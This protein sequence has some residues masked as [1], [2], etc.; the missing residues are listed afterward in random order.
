MRNPYTPGS[1]EDEEIDLIF[2]RLADLQQDVVSPTIPHIAELCQRISKIKGFWEEGETRNKA[3]MIALMHSEL[4]EA[5]EA[6]RIDE[7]EYSQKA[8]GCTILEEE[9]A[10]VV[11]R[12]FDF[13]HGFNLK[14]TKAILNKMEYNFSRPYKHG[15]RF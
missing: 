1:P 15:K 7:N 13:C 14:L 9:M 12:V 8:T 2:S 4:S 3:E 11:I 5:L 10:D 6:L